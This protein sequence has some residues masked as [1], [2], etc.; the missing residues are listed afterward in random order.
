MNNQKNKDDDRIILEQIIEGSEKALYK[1]YNKYNK[2]VFNFVASKI[3]DKYVADEIAQDIMIQFLER[4]RD[5]RFQCS[6][7]TFLMVVAKNK[8]VDYIRR[9]KTAGLIVG[10]LPDFIIENCYHVFFDP[11]LENKE[12]RALLEK[13][14]SLIPH[15]YAKVLRLK[16]VDNLSIKEI[17]HKLARSFKST[18]SLVFR[19]RKAFI[20]QYEE[21]EKVFSIVPSTTA[22]RS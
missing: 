19:A 17:A 6:I 14:F 1:F 2:I 8:I 21:S 10:G 13:V 12:L 22:K 4:S 16:Y 5:F 20:S 11:K 3:T 9:K 15:D 7:R 18:E